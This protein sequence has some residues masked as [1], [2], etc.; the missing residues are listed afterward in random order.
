LQK[1]TDPEGSRM[2][3]IPEFIELAHEGVKVDN[4]K[5]LPHL[6]PKRYSWYFFL[7]MVESIP[8]P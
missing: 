8:E 5:H 6:S 1:W 7:L 4:P 2:L 3:R